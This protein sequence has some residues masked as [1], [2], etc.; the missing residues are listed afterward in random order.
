MGTKA[1]IA[2]YNSNTISVIDT[3]T[4]TVTSTVNVGNNP[5]GVAVNPAGTKVYVTNGASNTVSAIGTATNTVTAT[6]N[7]GNW[8]FTFGQFIVPNKSGLPAVNEQINLEVK[9]PEGAVLT[10]T[11]TMPP[12]LADGGYYP[13]Y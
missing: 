10:I 6:V 4:N 12:A 11:R 2:N 5:L 3:S 13:V 1:Y 8:P 7:V 9:P